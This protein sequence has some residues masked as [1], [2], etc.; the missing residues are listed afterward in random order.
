ML[1]RSTP[2]S[3]HGPS[4]HS[5]TASIVREAI[6][7]EVTSDEQPTEHHTGCAPVHGTD[8]PDTIE[9]RS[10]ESNADFLRLV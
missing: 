2:R 6:D 4:E 7:T 10:S 5:R 8:F 1:K 3:D 9:D